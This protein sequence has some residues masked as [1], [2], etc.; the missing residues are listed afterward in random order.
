LQEAGGRLEAGSG[1]RGN[2]DSN[3]GTSCRTP[4]RTIGYARRHAASSVNITRTEEA[5]RYVLETYKHVWSP[6]ATDKGVDGDRRRDSVAR[7]HKSCIDE[8]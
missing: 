8:V 4:C 5:C 1:R 2:D 6:D 7:T 3:H